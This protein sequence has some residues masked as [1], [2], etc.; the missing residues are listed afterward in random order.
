MTTVREMSSLPLLVLLLTIAFAVVEPG[1][2][3]LIA[4]ML[5]LSMAFALEQERRQRHIG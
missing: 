3:A 2:A 1:T 4:L 5:L